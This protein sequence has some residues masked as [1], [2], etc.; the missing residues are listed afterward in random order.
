MKQRNSDELLTNEN[1]NFEDLKELDTSL[2][3]EPFNQVTPAANRR[4]HLTVIPEHL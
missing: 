1:I 3:E 2:S 4:S